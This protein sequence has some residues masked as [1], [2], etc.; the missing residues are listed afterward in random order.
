MLP[1]NFVVT[2]GLVLYWLLSLTVYQGNG[3]QF[4]ARSLKVFNV[5]NHNSPSDN[6]VF[7]LDE[8]FVMATLTT[9]EK[10]LLTEIGTA[11]V[12]DL[13]NCTCNDFPIQVTAENESDLRELVAAIADDEDHKES[14]LQEI[15]SGELNIADWI[16][17]QYLINKVVK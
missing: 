7:Q 8:S 10:S 11:A 14:M 13:S 3:V 6:K 5:V 1:T 12:S 9:L 15:V 4:S 2:Y 17:L 16:M